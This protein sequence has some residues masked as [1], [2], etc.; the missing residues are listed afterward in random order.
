MWH[1]DAASFG[2]VPELLMAANL[3]DFVPAVRAAAEDERK[4][5]QK[6]R[7]VQ[8]APQVSRST[9]LKSIDSFRADPRYG[10]DGTRMDLAY[11]IYAASHGA[12]EAEIEAQSGRGIYRTRA[13]NAGRPIT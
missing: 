7:S 3:I 10:D 8:P 2:R 5:E 11:A 6:R 9:E 13:G 12:T 4:R 1:R